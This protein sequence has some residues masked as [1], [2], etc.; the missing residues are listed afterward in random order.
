MLI[1]V[2]GAEEIA[3]E[4]TLYLERRRKSPL[5]AIGLIIGYLDSDNNFIPTDEELNY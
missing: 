2:A 5:P 4:S 1:L 3:K